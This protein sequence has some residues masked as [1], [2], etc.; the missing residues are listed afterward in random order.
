MQLQELKSRVWSRVDDAPTDLTVIQWFDDAQNRLASALGAK[1][2]KFITNNKFDPTQ[3]PVWDEKWHEALVVF[4][5]ARY[6][7]METSLSEVQNFQMQFE[8]LKAEMTENYQIPLQYRDDRL[9]QQFTAI[10]GQ[11]D[12][13]IT[14]LGY[15]PVYG[16]LQ[17]FINGNQTTDFRKKTDGTKGFILGATISLVSGDTVTALWDEHYDYQE[18]PYPWW[19]GGNGW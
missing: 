3:E 4:A 16:D 9:V 10:D 12:F 13:T 17:V 15:E 1:F 6:K 7:E 5:C 19:G 14:K 11:T 2:P 18:A 8:D